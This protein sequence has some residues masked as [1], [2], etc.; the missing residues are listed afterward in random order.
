MNHLYIWLKEFNIIHNL[1]LFSRQYLKFFQY[2]NLKS[3]IGSEFQGKY[4]DYYAYCV[5]KD[6][7]IDSSLQLHNE[8]LPRKEK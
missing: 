5:I 7:Q 4:T 1:Q 3:I 6:S 8:S 2:T